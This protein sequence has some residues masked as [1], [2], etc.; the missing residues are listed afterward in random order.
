MSWRYYSEEALTLLNLC[1]GFATN[2][3]AFNS[4]CT[5]L[6]K[7]CNTISYPLASPDS[8]GVYLLNT[9]LHMLYSNCV[10]ELLSF[11]IL[12]FL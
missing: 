11:P 12:Y 7:P 6:S 1:E 4:F 9:Y 8:V 3:A 2:P 5:I 10:L